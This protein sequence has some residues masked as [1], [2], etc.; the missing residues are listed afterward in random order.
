[1]PSASQPLRRERSEGDGI[2]PVVESGE[3]RRAREDQNT[4]L[5]RLEVVI[6]WKTVSPVST[7]ET[8]R[9]TPFVVEAGRVGEGCFGVALV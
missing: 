6:D 5:D 7:A 9:A 3:L 2:A 4:H 1:M 8:P